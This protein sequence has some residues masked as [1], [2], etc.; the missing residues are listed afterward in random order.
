MSLHA[1]ISQPADFQIMRLAQ[2]ERMC[3]AGD[4]SSNVPIILYL[5]AR[6]ADEEEHVSIIKLCPYKEHNCCLDGPRTVAHR[7]NASCLHTRQNI[8]K[9]KQAT[10]LTRTGGQG[11]DLSSLAG[12]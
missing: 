11:Q 3:S 8:G 12:Q 1:H 10:L 2:E 9:V 6:K 7:V 4:K 5:H